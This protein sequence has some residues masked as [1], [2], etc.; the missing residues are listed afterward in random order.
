M[1]KVMMIFGAI[2]FAS[3]IMVSCTEKA[4]DIQLSDLKTVCDYVDAMEKVC[5]AAIKTRGDKSL[6][7]LSQEEKDYL[8]VL[9]AKAK[10]IGKAAKKKYTEKEAKECSNFERMDAK[11][12]K[13][14]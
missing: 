1:K 6:E 8:K 4:E 11:G 13:A 10:D 12:E 9:K 7:D 14:F 3:M 2:S 5:D